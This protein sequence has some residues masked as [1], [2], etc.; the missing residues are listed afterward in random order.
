[1]KYG[2]QLYL[3]RDYCTDTE[4]VSRTIR[5]L[6]EMGYDSIEFHGSAIAPAQEMRRVIAENCITPLNVHID[7]DVWRKEW[8][9]G[10]DRAA[11]AGL[12][13]VTF[14]WIPPEC[15]TPDEY[16]WVRDHLPVFARGCEERGLDIYY[17]NHDF[18]FSQHEGQL[19]LDWLIAD[20]GSVKV[21]LDTFWAKYADFDPLE[22]MEKYKEKLEL[23]HIKDYVSL[24]PELQ[25]CPIGQGDMDNESIL[26]KVREAGLKYVISDLDNSTK[27]V[28][29]TARES[30]IYLK[31]TTS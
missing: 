8:Q 6:A 25:F 7:F 21:Q 31:K 17:H 10:V 12:Q 29:Q 5:Q 3:F 19:L 18:E 26:R 24:K 27:D 16:S 1:M 28:F 30:L 9:K 4:G 15:R 20:A 14:G 22:T 11:E 23:L 2:I 13:A